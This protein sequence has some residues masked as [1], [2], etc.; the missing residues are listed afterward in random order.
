M[1]KAVCPRKTR[2]ARK[3]FKDS[4]SCKSLVNMLIVGVI[5]CGCP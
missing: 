1:E 5:S 2:K 3:K 4:L